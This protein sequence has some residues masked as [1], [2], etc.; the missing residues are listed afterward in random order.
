[1]S[2]DA[3]ELEVYLENYD[4]TLEGVKA[5][6]DAGEL[7]GLPDYIINLWWREYVRTNLKIEIRAK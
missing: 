4:E 3:T 5:I 6:V 1:M 7:L 2:L